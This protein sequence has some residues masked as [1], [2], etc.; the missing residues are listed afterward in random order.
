[1]AGMRGAFEAVST[2]RVM[3][4]SGFYNRRGG[5]IECV[6]VSCLHRKLHDGPARLA[7][8]LGVVVEGSERR[9][10]VL[11]LLELDEA[12]APAAGLALGVRASGVVQQLGV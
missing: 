7:E 12:D 3:K 5:R 8:H 9:E 11:V 10:R 6:D 2:N 4:G 1:M